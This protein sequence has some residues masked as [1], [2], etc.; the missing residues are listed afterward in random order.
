MMT[1]KDLLKKMSMLHFNSPQSIHSIPRHIPKWNWVLRRGRRSLFK[2]NHYTSSVVIN[3]ILSLTEEKLTE[4]CEMWILDN[5][6]KLKESKANCFKP[7]RLRK[8]QR[9]KHK[10]KTPQSATR[11]Q[12]ICSQ[13]GKSLWRPITCDCHLAHPRSAGKPYE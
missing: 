13:A 5:N 7:P 10:R 1:S 3:W 4:S 11:S 6:F 8:R 9:C 12:T 2:K